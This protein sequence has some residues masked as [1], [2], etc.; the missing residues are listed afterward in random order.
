MKQALIIVDMQN[1][2]IGGSLKV[3]DGQSLTTTMKPM[4]AYGK[5]HDWLIIATRDW[6]PANH[7]SFIS[8]QDKYLDH[9]NF[10]AD[11]LWPDHCIMNTWG[12]TLVDGLPT[13]K[14]L[15]NKGDEA[16]IDA[17][18]AFGNLSKQNTTKLDALLKQNDISQIYL[19]G[20]AF[21]FCVKATAL[22]AVKLGYE[23]TV[24]TDLVRSTTNNVNRDNKI[25]IVLKKQ[26]V[27]FITSKKLIK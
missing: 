9:K 1:D 27:N 2:F 10:N 26:Q 11:E 19:C 17:Y 13:F 8:N 16:T 24:I 7:I 21:D 15:I 12:S 5:A 18:S 22:D 14:Y 20:V 23:T 4:I 3:V 6:H 25:K